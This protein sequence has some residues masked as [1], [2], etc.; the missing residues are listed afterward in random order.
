M[1]QHQGNAELPPPYAQLSE[2]EDDYLPEETL[3]ESPD[4]TADDSS[5]D[6]SYEPPDESSDEVSDDSFDQP[7][8]PDNRPF[9]LIE[10]NYIV[11]G[12]KTIKISG[13]HVCVTFE[14]SLS[15]N[16]EELFEALQKQIILPIRP[17]LEIHGQHSVTYAVKRKGQTDWY[18]DFSLYL[19]LAETLLAGW[20]HTCTADFWLRIKVVK[21]E[22]DISAFRG[23]RRLTLEYKTPWSKKSTAAAGKTW[24]ALQDVENGEYACNG[25]G[26]DYVRWRR[27]RGMKDVHL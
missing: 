9:R 18:T 10:K 5:D 7:D 12:G 19:D 25:G 6:P 2:P 14:P 13:K 27:L 16:S 4:Q 17:Y 11:P 3:R 8:S 21:D 20:K 23:S 22:D 1:G 24:I 26:A 15:N